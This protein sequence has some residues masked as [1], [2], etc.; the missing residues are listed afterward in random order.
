MEDGGQG[1]IKSRGSSSCHFEHKVIGHWSLELKN[2]VQD[3]MHFYFTL[4]STKFSSED[5]LGM[6]IIRGHGHVDQAQRDDDNVNLCVDL[7][8]QFV[9]L[10]TYL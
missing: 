4:C 3:E 1:G 10:V 9:D 2:Q 5:W 8:V 7:Q 6:H